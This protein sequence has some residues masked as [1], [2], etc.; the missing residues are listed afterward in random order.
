MMKLTSRFA[1]GAVALSLIG[2]GAAN[3]AVIYNESVSGDLSNSGLTP[4]GL[5]VSIGSNQIFGTTGA[6]TA[7]D[8]DYFK[9]TV[10]V[11]LVLS[12]IT[13]LPGTQN[14]GP[15]GDSFFGVE[16]GPQVTVPVLPADATGLLGWIHYDAGDVG[17]NILPE[18]GASDFGATGFKPPL[19]S[20]TYSFWLQ[21][22]NVGTV[23]YGLD[24][25]ITA[26]PE[27]G[28]WE[29]LVLCLALFGIQAVH[30]RWSRAA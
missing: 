27:P 13:I 24:F 12:A 6:D 23:P 26:A 7:P 5:T 16:A 25:T 29:M 8:R 21:E 10:P 20:G 14:L 2:S 19:P 17:T 9:F 4:T 22:G 15:N 18:M 28:S 11:G 3:A 1:I 30:K